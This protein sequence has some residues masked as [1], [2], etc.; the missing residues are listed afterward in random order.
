MCKLVKIW[1]SG[2]CNS[3][4]PCQKLAAQF[5]DYVKLAT[6]FPEQDKSDLGMTAVKLRK[7]FL[8]EQK[9]TSLQ[10]KQL[11]IRENHMTL[12]LGSDVLDSLVVPKRYLNLSDDEIVVTFV[13][14]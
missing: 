7:E 6:N 9:R 5:V 1:W 10:E 4:Y 12:A 2:K 3:G 8:P 11:Q 13:V 14:K